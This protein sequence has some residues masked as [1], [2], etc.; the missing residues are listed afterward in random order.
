MQ[1]PRSVVLLIGQN[2][3]VKMDAC[4]SMVTAAFQEARK[5]FRQV[6]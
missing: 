3:A 6:G 4:M 2:V 1:P 5:V